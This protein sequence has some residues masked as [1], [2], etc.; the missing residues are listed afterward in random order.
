MLVKFV[1]FNFS[2]IK[3]Y[4]FL[5]SFMHGFKYFLII[6]LIYNFPLFCLNQLIEVNLQLYYNQIYRFIAQKLLSKSLLSK[7]IIMEHF[8]S[9]YNIFFYTQQALVFHFLVDSCIV[10]NHI[11]I[12]F[13]FLLQKDFD[14]ICELF[15]L[16]FFIILIIFR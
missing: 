9:F 2:I 7:I 14:I 12:F 1:F 13:L 15:L 8:F 11:V 10:H 6:F 16:T 5:S 4:N 3:L